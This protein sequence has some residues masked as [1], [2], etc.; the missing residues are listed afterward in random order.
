M[1]GTINDVNEVGDEVIKFEAGFVTC[2]HI[3]GKTDVTCGHTSG[4]H[5]MNELLVDCVEE[6]S[7]DVEE[8]GYCYFARAPG[9]LYLVGDKVHGIG[10]VLTEL[11]TKLARREHIVFFG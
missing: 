6:G 10:G 5:T 8:E 2:E 7:L 9:V 11:T 4:F 3:F 1:G